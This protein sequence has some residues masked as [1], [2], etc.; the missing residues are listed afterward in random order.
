MNGQARWLWTPLLLLPA[1]AGADEVHLTSGGVVRGVIVERTDEAVVIETG[2][3]RVTLPLSRVDRILDGVS[4]LATFQQRA[5]LIAFDD[6]EGLAEL[7]R[8]AADHELAT[9]SR[10]TWERVL[11]LDPGH[12][13][14]NAALGRVFVDGV[15][16][17][18]RDAYRA[19]G[20]VRFEGQ[21]VTPAEH[22]G[23]LREQS[24]RDLR[25]SDRREAEL[26]VREAEARA[27]EAE[28]RAREAETHAD[29][30]EEP[31]NGIPYWWVLAGGGG[32]GGWPP[33]GSVPPPPAT[34]PE[35]PVR[36]PYPVHPPMKT[37]PGQSIW[38]TSPPSRPPV[39]KPHD[40]SSG[41]SSSRRGGSRGSSVR[42]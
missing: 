27:R 25:A 14:A 4:A 35:E 6:V 10:A 30:A 20:Y 41:R 34:L 2:P 5:A 11:A 17:S 12:P 21:W 40:G 24:E 9:Y 23:L 33:G 29:R 19:Q 7:A 42:D 3:G 28:A 37:R 1:L 31:V 38:K 16:M 18:E 32:W 26:R 13:E 8:W 36:P 15:W 22:E 39:A